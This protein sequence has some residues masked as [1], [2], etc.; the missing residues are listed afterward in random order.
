MA[1]IDMHQQMRAHL[2]KAIRA[3][4]EISRRDGNAQKQGRIAAYELHKDPD[5]LDLVAARNNEREWANTYAAVIIATSA[6]YPQR[7]TT[8]AP[9]SLPGPQRSGEPSDTR[10]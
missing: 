7:Y 2:V 5:F 10:T 9:G 1:E 4:E 3:Q 8:A 6:A